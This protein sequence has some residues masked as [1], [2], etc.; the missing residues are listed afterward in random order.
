[1]IQTPLPRS[2]LRSATT[3]AL[4][5]TAAT[6]VGCAD[7]PELDATAQE[8]GLVGPS[9]C[10]TV[11]TDVMKSLVVTEAET[12][13]LF[14]FGRVMDHVLASVKHDPT[15]TRLGLWQ[16][17][18]NTYAP[19][20]CPGPGVDPN[21]Y[22]IVCP[23]TREASLALSD[24]YAPL[25]PDF[26]KPVAVFNRFDLAPQDGSH[27]GEYR[28]VFAKQS[29]SNLDR[30]FLIFEAVLPNPAPEKGLAA[31]YPVA[32][33]WQSL[34]GTSPAKRA[35]A[36]EEF[37]FT[38]L[39]GFGPVVD[40]QNYGLIARRGGLRLFGYGDSARPG[41]VRTN[42]FVDA[43]GQFQWNLREFKLDL[44]C[45]LSPSTAFDTDSHLVERPLPNN[46]RLRFEHG[47]DANNPANEL[48]SSTHANAPDF[49]DVFVAKDLESLAVIGGT[50]A[51][52][53][54][55][56]V[57]GMATD[58]DFNEFESVASGL[59]DVVYN[60]FT[61]PAFRTAITNKLAVLS[62]PLSASQL[63]NRAT[64]Q[65][66]AGCHQHSNGADVG[67]NFTWPASAGFVHVTETSA[68]S[69][70]LTTAFL[71]F[72]KCVLDSFIARICSGDELEPIDE[73]LTVG[74]QGVGA[75]N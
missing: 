62:S 7:D 68:L 53:G 61:A 49:Q 18:M 28:I 4:T 6:L 70:A 27:C 10:P 57:F 40:A 41:Q 75:A 34:S 33:F 65:T 17:W 26:F 8:V 56:N 73:N 24:P 67:A 31:C 11:A 5:L 12:L 66:C 30:G 69:P 36:L 72:R 3:I 43:A 44:D 60:N 23:R 52:G 21:G 74:G 19:A 51:C 13:A 16:A 1:M 35:A 48:F 55:S 63:L 59:T 15:Q 32:R 2:R 45:S 54:P 71:P 64:T 37:Y 14:S 20:P 22:G 42:M 50:A 46:C 47:P 58:D 39:N 38:G 25:G 29:A 9:T